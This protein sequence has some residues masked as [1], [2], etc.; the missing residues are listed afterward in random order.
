MIFINQTVG[1]PF[2]ERHSGLIIDNGKSSKTKYSGSSNVLSLAFI[3]PWDG[4]TAINGIIAIPV[5]HCIPVGRT[6]TLIVCI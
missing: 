5:K 2:S 4:H 1:Y 6:G 3:R